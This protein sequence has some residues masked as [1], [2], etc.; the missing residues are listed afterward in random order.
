M[1]RPVRV[2]V[3]REMCDNSRLVYLQYMNAHKYLLYN[4]HN[5]HDPMAELCVV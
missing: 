2:V 4:H 1:S 5:L 3:G